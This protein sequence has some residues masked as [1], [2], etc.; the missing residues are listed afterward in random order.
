MLTLRQRLGLNAAPLVL[1]VVVGLIMLW[2]GLGK[3]AGSVGVSGPDA[4]ALANMGVIK[5][6]ARTN[7]DG[8]SAKLTP[9]DF[10]EPREVLRLY[11][12]ALLLHVRANPGS[13]EAGKPRMILWPESLGRGDWPVRFAWAAA[14]TEIVA[15]ACLL[16][17]L[18]TRWMA[19]AVV[20]V[21]LVAT[22]LTEFG[23]ALQSGKTVL[24][25]FPEKQPFY[26][27][28]QWS[29]FMLQW[30]LIA[31]GVALACLGSGRLALDGAIRR[32]EGDDDDAE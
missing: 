15:G 20:G 1:R 11:R 25:L 9:E 32:G 28:A 17:G 10:K 3:L 8:T 19:A 14:I 5:E 31:M 2:A 30:C 12:L 7:A 16:L 21:M 24:G 29:T 6:P 22:W 4:L 23:P 18:F 26:D 27:P 13:D